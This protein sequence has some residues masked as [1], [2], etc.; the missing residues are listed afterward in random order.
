M[1]NSSVDKIEFLDLEIMIKNGKLETNLF[2]K[3][4]LQLY[5]DYFSNHP[6]HC[7]ESLI[8]SQALRILE[9]CSSEDDAQHHLDI[10]NEKL[11]ERNYPDT[12]I[13]KKIG[14]AQKRTREDILRRRPKRKKDNKVRLVFT[15][16]QSNPPVQKWIRESKKVLLKNEEAKE[17]GD[18]IQV[19]WRQPRNLKNTVCGLKNKVVSAKAQPSEDPGCFKCRKCKVVCP[20][21]KEGLFFSSTN[22]RKQYRIQH[23]LTC[24]S[25]FVI[26]LATCKRCHG[27]YVGKSQTILK[28]R[29]SNHKREIKN[30]IG[31]LGNHY[32]GE[33]GCGYNNFS[34]QIIDKVE[35]GNVEALAQ[36]EQYWQDQLRV[37]VENGGNGQCRRKEK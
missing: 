28:M 4:N 23:H 34:L 14:E 32:G 1:T 17:I 19:G 25:S 16:N 20:I 3:P 5:L 18:N 26:Y 21:L 27:Q 8:Y 35:E 12:L 24:T 30:K 11:Q 15:H 22:T 2:V 6:N 37:F 33:Q 36:C 10:L 9:R 29:H 7:K 13:K 31:G